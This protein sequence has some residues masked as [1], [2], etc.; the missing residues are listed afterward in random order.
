[1]TAH[2][3]KNETTIPTSEAG[4]ADV[5]GEH[6]A[7]LEALVQ[8]RGAERGK[9]EQERELGRRPRGESRELPAD[10]RAHRAR[11][12]RPERQAL[13]EADRQRAPRGHVFEAVLPRHATPARA[14]ALDDDHRDASHDER[15][16]DRQRSEEVGLD[17][18]AQEQAADGGGRERDGERDEQACATRGRPW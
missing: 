1:M 5:R 9:G 17:G 2:A 14:D 10:D 13:P 18:L 6:M 11:R 4:G 7:R 3:T 8:R 15:S 12:P 16:R